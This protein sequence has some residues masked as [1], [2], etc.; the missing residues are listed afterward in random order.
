[1][2]LVAFFKALP[3]ILAAL[4]SL[5]PLLQKI[6]D[7]VERMGGEAFLEQLVKTMDAWNKA[8]TTEEMTNAAKDLARFARSS[9]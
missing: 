2:S 5:L 9:R 4:P 7:T 6:V 1:M 3:T 8:Q